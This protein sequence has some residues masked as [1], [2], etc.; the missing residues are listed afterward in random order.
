MKMANVMRGLAVATLFSSLGPIACGSDSGSGNQQNSQ[1]SNK[2]GDSGAPTTAPTTAPATS[3]SSAV[4]AGSVGCGSNVCAQRTDLTGAPCCLDMFG[5]VCGYKNALQQCV[6]AP[7]PAPPECP[8]L[9]TIPGGFITLVGCCTTKGECGIDESMLGM[10][11]INYSDANALTS[12]FS[13]G[14]GAA[15]M[16]GM[17][18]NLNIT[19]PAE[20]SC[21]PGDGGS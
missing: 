18:F 5:G 3:A 9:P 2:K 17:G 14:M 1:N 7:K 12:M 11:C 4:P 15:G 10:G 16:G 19:L 6:Q 21:T 8:M 20:A 13:G